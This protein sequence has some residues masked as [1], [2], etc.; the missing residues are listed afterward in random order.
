MDF[1]ILGAGTWGIT[2][3]ELLNFNKHS[4]S[5]WHYNPDYI[6]ELKAKRFHER[7][8]HNIS[9]EI[10]FL[11]NTKEINEIMMVI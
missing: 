9:E 11:S 8:N 5:I 4:V 10:N 6:S 2:L 1:T 3:A 7:L